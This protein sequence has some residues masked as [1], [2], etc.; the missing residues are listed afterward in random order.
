VELQKLKKNGI[1]NC[2]LCHF[3]RADIQLGMSVAKGLG[4][5]MKIKD[6]YPELFKYLDEMSVLFHQKK[7]R[8]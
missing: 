8:K 5:T 2:Q 6:H 1:I 4:V 3:F 7:I